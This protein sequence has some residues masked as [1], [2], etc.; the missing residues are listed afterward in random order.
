VFSDARLV[1]GLRFHALVAAAAAGRPFVAYAH[2][3]KLAAAARRLGQP[4]I[5]PAGGADELAAVLLSAANRPAA[6]ALSAVRAEIARA[7]ETMRLLR[8]VLSDGRTGEP[9]EIGTLPLEPA[10]WAS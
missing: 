8:L 3:P 7:E 10:E 6:P 2:E 1:V 9:E 4:A 5:D